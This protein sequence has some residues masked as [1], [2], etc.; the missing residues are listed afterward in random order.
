ML[1]IQSLLFAVIGHGSITLPTPR[2]PSNT[3]RAGSCADGQCLWFSQ[4]MEIPGEP[5]LNDPKHRTY[6]VFVSSGE[7]DW[8]RKMPWRSPGAS[9]VLGHGCGVAGGGSTARQN[10]GTPPDGYKQGADGLEMPPTEPT[11]WVRGSVQEVGWGLLANHGGGYQWRICRNDGN[12]TVS[13]ECFQ[14]NPLRF[15]DGDVQ[16]IRYGDMWQKLY[17]NFSGPFGQIVVPDFKIPRVIV[18]DGTT[19]NGSQWA[20]NPIPGCLL[21]DQYDC[22]VQ[23]EKWLQQQHCS[24]TC[25]GL[26][27]NMGCPPGHTQFEPPLPG[28]AGYDPVGSPE[29][30]IDG[31]PYSIIDHVVVPRDIE[32]GPYLL[33]WRWDCEQSKQIWQNCADIL[34]Q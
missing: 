7:K 25:S 34:I 24:Q 19:P 5:T 29:A 17:G 30:R 22:M 26:G 27:L 20:R 3:S 32:P 12:S 18:T 31:F 14:Q 23:N 16:W 8:S 13:E 2:V 21:C 9:P 33:S 10:G 1:A 15:A 6:N 11:V 28:L 4:P